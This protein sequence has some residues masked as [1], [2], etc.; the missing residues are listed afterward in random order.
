MRN[1]KLLIHE[2]V[3][4]STI[5]VQQLRKKSSKFS[6]IFYQIINPA[7]FNDTL[8]RYNRKKKNTAPYNTV[9]M[10]KKGAERGQL[11]QQVDEGDPQSE[12]SLRGV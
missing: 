2:K 10:K 3:T 8:L 9:E 7:T 5:S 4:Q 11:S 1:C 6:T 12:G